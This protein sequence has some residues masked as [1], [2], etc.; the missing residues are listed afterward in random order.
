MKRAVI[1]GVLILCL[2]LGVLFLSSANSQVVS[3]GST[4]IFD[5]LGNLR[6]SLGDCLSGESACNGTDPNSY[7]KVA[8]GI[9]RATTA[10]TG[11][12]TNTTSATFTLPAGAKTLLGKVE[13]TGAVTQTQTLYG[14]YDSTAANGIRL[15]SVTLSGTTKDVKRGSGQV[16]EDF[17]FYYVI[18]T[19][20]T[21]TGATGELIVYTGLATETP[22]FTTSAIVT[23]DTLVVSGAAFLQCIFI[24]TND[25]APTAGTII[26]Y[27]NTAES[28]TQVLNWT[29]TIAVFNPI[30][31]C[32]QRQMN[33]GIYIGFTTTADVNV[34]VSYR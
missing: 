9:P 25:A 26:V 3:G 2:L 14:A 23:G 28:G 4:F 13:G 29:L 12:T 33:N 7:L 34:S 15:A 31:I 8:P 18:T 11:V 20:T 24:T 16:A 27:D 32:P 17:P 30:Q 1:L 19:N 6:V 5:L 10:I 21:G 22:S